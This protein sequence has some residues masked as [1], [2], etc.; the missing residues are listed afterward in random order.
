MSRHLTPKVI[1]ILFF[2][3]VLPPVLLDVA[4]QSRS[5]GT[6]QTFVWRLDL[7]PL[8]FDAAGM[9]SRLQIHKIFGRVHSEV[10]VVFGQEFDIIVGS[11][12]ARKYS[13]AGKHFLLQNAQKSC[14]V[15]SQRERGNICWSRAQRHQIT[16]AP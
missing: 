9:S 3:S 8:A 10:M 6:V 15:I 12:L 16:A 13:C 2:K 1:D 4:F 14:C 7:L 5:V 11:P